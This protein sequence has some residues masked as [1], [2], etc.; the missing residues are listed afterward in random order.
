MFLETLT[1]G[2]NGPPLPCCVF[3]GWALA[4]V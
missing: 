4:P 3:R 1:A 2:C